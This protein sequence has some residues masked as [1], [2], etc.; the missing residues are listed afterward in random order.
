MHCAGPFRPTL[1]LYCTHRCCITVLL[2]TQVLYKY[3]K[4]QKQNSHKHDTPWKDKSL[5]CHPITQQSSRLFHP[6][7]VVSSEPCHYKRWQDWKTQCMLSPTQRKLRSATLCKSQNLPIHNVL[8]PEDMHQ[9][10]LQQPAV[11]RCWGGP[12]SPPLAVTEQKLEQNFWI[13]I[14]SE[15][16]FR[17][18]SDKLNRS[19]CSWKM[20]LECNYKVLTKLC[21]QSRTKIV[22]KQKPSHPS[23]RR[24]CTLPSLCATALWGLFP[25]TR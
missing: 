14:L 10:L 3:L 24:G 5:I 8:L 1:L 20:R 6:Q 9:T 4:T 12:S 21:Q 16:K 11:P 23:C 2:Q 13:C 7:R 17:R 25:K 19:P 22:D 18:R 15:S